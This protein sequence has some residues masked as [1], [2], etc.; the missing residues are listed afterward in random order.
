MHVVRRYRSLGYVLDPLPNH[1]SSQA[2]TGRVEGNVILFC[3]AEGRWIEV[4]LNLNLKWPR[5]S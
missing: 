3:V 5:L 2:W 4:S 1:R